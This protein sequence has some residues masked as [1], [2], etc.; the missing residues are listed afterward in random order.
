MLNDLITSKTRLQLLIKF[1]ISAANSGYLRGLAQEMD[2]NTNAIRKELNHLS[3]AGYILRDTT[4]S[5]IMYRA[6]TAHPLFST[7]QQLVRK[8][9]GID[10]IITQVMERMGEVSKIY[11]TGDYAQGIDSGTIAVVVEGINVNEEYL[12]QLAPKI[13]KEIKKVV[14]FTVTPEF[15]GSGLLIFE[16]K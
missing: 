1:F 7:L 6:N 5:K 13:E 4:T 2:E 9:L 15:T 8:H 3:D 10:E 12:V 16:N 11:L 14:Q